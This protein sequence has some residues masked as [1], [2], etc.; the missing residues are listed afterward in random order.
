MHELSLAAEVIKIAEYEAGRNNANLVSEITIEAGSFSGVE[1][2]AFKSALEIL[3]EGTVLS[4]ASLN[5]LKI[6]GK[7]YCQSCDLEFEMDNRIDT[8]PVCNSF[9]SEIRSGYEFRV[10][11][12]VVENDY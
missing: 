7:G 11:S 8:C 6:K 10:K 12:L 3:A 9:P 2:D 5:I 4:K 1:I